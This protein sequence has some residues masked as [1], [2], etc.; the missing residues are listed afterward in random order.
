M[1]YTSIS[2]DSSFHGR[3]VTITLRRPETHNALNTQLIQELTAAFTS[4]HTDK[5]L[6]AVLLQAEGRS[7]SAGADIQ[8][9]KESARLS[10]VEN[11]QDALRIA[12]MLSSIETC[13]C[14][15]VARVQG[16][17]IGG[18]VGL[19]A[20]SDIVLAAEN[21][22]FAFSEVKLGIA[23]AVI[24]PYVLR[25]IGQSHARALFTTGTRFSAT[26]AYEIG[27][28]HTVVPPEGLDAVVHNTL[29]E[30]LAG[31]PQ[32]LRACKTLTLRIG[33]MGHE[34]AR[35]VTAETIARLR[36]SAEGQEGLSAFLEKRTP[37][38]QMKEGN[39]VQK[40]SDR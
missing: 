30:L 32:A 35:N 28:V 19:L 12:D 3:I 27:L 10:E 36:V 37:A 2:V 22:R 26:R 17:A 21:A 33:Q 38:W 34:Q 18:G 24:S 25:K 39:D 6:H 20:A 16:S 9:M 4:L 1:V 40:S 14:P 7:F 5:R 15:V 29:Q 8:M 23:P 13:P 31:S 11:M